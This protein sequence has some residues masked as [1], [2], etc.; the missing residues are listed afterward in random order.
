VP[1]VLTQPLPPPPVA[2]TPSL[3][4]ACL[5]FFPSTPSQFRH[6]VLLSWAV[7]DAV[8]FVYYL[9]S[10]GVTTAFKACAAFQLS[11]DFV[12]LVQTYLYRRQ[13]AQDQAEMARLAG[14][15]EGV[16][17]PEAGL[18]AARGSYEG[19]TRAGRE[20]GYADEEAGGK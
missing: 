11:V 10:P 3:A 6:S 18:M 16:A 14:G 20:R 8:K 9:L 1:L 15:V 2:T 4:L 5:P 7:G 19:E 17:G 13:T 12:L